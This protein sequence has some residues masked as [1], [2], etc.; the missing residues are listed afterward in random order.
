MP[1]YSHTDKSFRIS[2]AKDQNKICFE[3]IKSLKDMV[4]STH[5]ASGGN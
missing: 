4:R 5:A 3:N 1:T 2:F